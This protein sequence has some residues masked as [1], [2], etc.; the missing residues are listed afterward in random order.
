MKKSY[1]D[2][3]PRAQGSV[4]T[5]R[6]LIAVGGLAAGAS[7]ALAGSAQAATF[8]VT[9]LSDSGSGSLRDAITQSNGASGANTITFA[10]GLSGTITLASHLPTITQPVGI[11][12][13]GAT[14]LTVSGGG[15]NRI[16]YSLSVPSNGDPVTI[17]GLS[18]VDANSG[19]FGGAISN[20]NAALTVKNATISG[21]S[22]DSAAGISSFPPG[23]LTV[24]NSTIS[25]NHAAHYEGGIFARGEVTIQSSTI[26]GNTAERG[27]GGLFITYPSSSSLIANST[28]ANNTE[29]Y[30]GA[31]GIGIGGGAD[32]ELR[33]VDSTISG[34]HANSSPSASDRGGGGIYVYSGTVKLEDTI[35]AG[36]TTS[37]AGTASDIRGP[38]GAAFSLIGDPSGATI[39][40]TVAGS[41]ITGADPQ[42]GALQNNGGPTQTMLPAATSPVIDKGSAFGLSSDQ[43]G[44]LR[45]IDFPSIPNSNVAGADG[46]DIGAVELQPSN[47]L[48]LAGLKRNK[49]KGTAVQTVDLPTPD[50]GSV[51]LAGKFLKTQAHAV[52][53]NGVVNLKLI[54]KGKLR[55]L[56]KRKGKVRTREMITYNPSGQSPNSVAKKIKLIKKPR[57]R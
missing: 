36:N 14:A 8:T 20:Y 39:T 12:G 52:A 24:I 31:G 49:K 35:V 13:P 11:E 7:L 1:V 6:R 25:G 32:S 48:A 50:A 46:S 21:N 18:L 54:P 37:S 51:T 17:A 42:L 9:N 45:P 5:R 10:S 15:A 2:G 23:S 16:F 34:N 44:V 47:A 55:K 41:T 4:P 19:G 43:R 56:L 30:Y 33:I 22:A 29:N 27:D 28:I 40:D 53:D 3:A 57:H 26:S 38:L